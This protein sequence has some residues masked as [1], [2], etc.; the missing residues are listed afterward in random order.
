[1]NLKDQYDYYIFMDNDVVFENI[2]QEEGFKKFEEELALKKP[3]IATPQ[4]LNYHQY[5]S[6]TLDIVTLNPELCDLSSL[7]ESVIW[8]DALMNAFSKEVFFGNSIFPYDTTYDSSA[9]L[10]SQLILIIKS[11]Y[12]YNKKVLLFKDIIVKSTA[13]SDYP[14]AFSI[15][16]SKKIYDNVMKTIP[17]DL[18]TKY[19]VA[20]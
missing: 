7:E 10:Y 20:S 14:R 18:K 19:D 16:L 2:T 9:W 15:E 3:L 6:K 12:Y 11:Y 1:M 4:M 5:C 8:Y 17:E 13:N